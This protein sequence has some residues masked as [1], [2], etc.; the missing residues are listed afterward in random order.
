M[1]GGEAHLPARFKQQKGKKTMDKK[2][3]FAPEMESIEMNLNAA[4]LTG[5]L[6]EPTIGG[7]EQG[8]SEE[9][10]NPGA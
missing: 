5:S 6:E 8:Y 1:R 9:P 7:S 10:F 4:I 3:Y 2:L